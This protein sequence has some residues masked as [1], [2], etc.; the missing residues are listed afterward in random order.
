MAK[1]LAG[2]HGFLHV[3]GVL[4]LLR[5]FWRFGW[6]PSIH[7]SSSP[8][9]PNEVRNRPRTR[10]DHVS[11][12]PTPTAR[13]FLASHWS[14][15]RPCPPFRPFHW[16]TD[17]VPLR[18]LVESS[19]VRPRTSS[20]RRGCGARILRAAPSN[21]HA[22]WRTWT[23]RRAVDWRPRKA[24]NA[25]RWVHRRERET[26]RREGTRVDGPGTRRKVEVGTTC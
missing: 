3:V 15:S 20:H 13:L 14:G 19:G 17:V 2:M 12:R 9:S 24:A 26:R 10:G 25:S 23:A 11:V 4:D 18:P 1:L 21:E 16:R 5:C 7:H 8:R 22:A 6:K